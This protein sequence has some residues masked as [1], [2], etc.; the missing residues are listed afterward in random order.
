MDEDM[1]MV[2]EVTVDGAPFTLEHV[3]IPLDDIEFDEENPR[4]QY[5]L[6]LLNSSKPL[7]EVILDMPEVNLLRK[8]IEK[9]GGLR[10]KIITQR[11]ANGKHKV[12]EGN[13]R[14]ACFRSLRATLKYKGDPRWETIP[15]RVIPH[16]VEERKVAILLSDMHVAGKISWKAHEKAGQIFRM[17]RVLKMGQGDIATYMRQS[18]STV[19][20]LLDAYAFMQERFLVIDEGAYAD[21]G[22]NKWSFFDELFRSRELKEELKHNPDFAD[23]FCRW[24]GDERLAEGM[25]VRD[26]PSIL[27]HPD[28][29]KK[30]EKLNKD[31]AFK[32]AMK[33]VES[34]EPEMGSEFFKLLS[35]MREECTSAAQVKEILKIRNDKVARARLL[36]TYEAFRDFMRLADV[37]P[38]AD[39]KA[40]AA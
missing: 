7:E 21:K 31:V 8:D 36:E 14:Y 28:A 2:E 24:V 29:K 6:A 16:D 25:N 39:V 19:N 5:R 9:N 15:A 26:L 13:C 40:N 22:E 17:N 32:E 34:A 12:R 1:K 30:F 27:K 11:R 3:N 4:I 10:E 33:L 38:D 37:D 20:R 23:D 18:K 35:K